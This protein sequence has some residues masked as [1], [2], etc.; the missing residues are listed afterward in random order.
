MIPRE[1]RLQHEGH[2]AFEPENVPE[3]AA[4]KMREGGPISAE[5][6][7]KRQAR[8]HPDTEVQKKEPAPEPRM[9]IPGDVLRAH[10][11]QFCHDQKKREP[12]CQHRPKNMEQRRGRE[13]HTRQNDD[14]VR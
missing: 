11:E 14:V 8:D 10:P 1:A 7:F 6:K 13:L 4:R 12:D 9:I 2:G 3:K 5:F